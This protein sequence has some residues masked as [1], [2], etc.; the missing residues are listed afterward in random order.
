[1]LIPRIDNSKMLHGFVVNGSE[2][3]I[4]YLG[5]LG[6]DGMFESS[7]GLKQGNWGGLSNVGLLGA[8]HS[9]RDQSWD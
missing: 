1:M 8:G 5:L 4:T 2:T 9:S 7:R 6:V 3:S